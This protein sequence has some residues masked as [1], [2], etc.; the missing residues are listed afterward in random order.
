MSHLQ[1]WA[2]HKHPS[3]A[4][5]AIMFSAL[6]EY[7]AQMISKTKDPRTLV[8]LGQLGQIPL[9]EW[10]SYYTN[11]RLYLQ[12][13]FNLLGNALSTEN[14]LT[15]EKKTPDILSKIF[16]GPSSKE[17]LNETIVQAI[18][19]NPQVIDSAV[20]VKD[21]LLRSFVF[22]LQ[23]A[24][25]CHFIYLTHPVKLLKDAR[26]GNLDSMEKLLRLDSSTLFDRKIANRLHSLRFTKPSEFAR[27]IDCANKPLKRKVT[28]QK[29]K[30][31]LASG[32][33]HMAELQNAP[34]TEP[35]I[36]ALFD[37]LAKDRGHGDIDSDIPDSPDAFSKALRRD[38]P[39]WREAIK[40]DKR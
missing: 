38:K 2:Q 30:V 17:Y 20:L 39:F 22:M 40:P 4:L 25:P 15:D 33:S 32:I 28:P 6:A 5:M 10:L 3:V 14:D 23:V 35:E 11:R 1:A 31:F 24:L 12:N 26:H 9:E 29:F 8:A 21:D 34:L 27:L 19:D 18:T 16:S 7:C 13:F 36:R 37:A